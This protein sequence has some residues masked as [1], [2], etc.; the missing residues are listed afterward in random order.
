[1]SSKWLPAG[2]QGSVTAPLGASAV[3]LSSAMTGVAL[4]GAIASCGI[5]RAFAAYVATGDAIS[6]AHLLCIAA[7]VVVAIGGLLILLRELQRLPE[8]DNCGRFGRYLVGLTF[9]LLLLGLWNS[10]GTCTLALGGG[11]EF[12]A[13]ALMESSDPQGI[14]KAEE[15]RLEAEQRLQMAQRNLSSLRTAKERS[16]VEFGDCTARNATANAAGKDAATAM[17]ACA[18]ARRQLW[19]AEDSLVKGQEEAADAEEALQRG[20]E[21]CELT[22]RKA[23]TAQFFLLAVSSTMALFGACFFVVNSVRRMRPNPPGGD[24]DDA[25]G[26]GRD[27]T[28][29]PANPGTPD[30][31]TAR[32]S[33]SPRTQAKEPEG[34]KPK[35]ELFD[36]YAFWSGGILPGRRSDAVYLR[37]LLADLDL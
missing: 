11:L 4:G 9:L 10:M 25:E 26:F 27:S 8:A 5:A 21:S 6:R 15:Q 12:S 37:L 32:D 31:A 14:K 23:R 1:M 36:S 13:A 20:K 33:A 29:P 34:D 30:L 35:E 24:S 28:P 17:D 22:R 16:Q 3:G 7:G 2:L 18:V 19:T